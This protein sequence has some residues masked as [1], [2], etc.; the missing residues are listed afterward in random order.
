MRVWLEGRYKTTHTILGGIIQVE[1]RVL[2][3]C[4]D[5]IN[6]MGQAM[7]NIVTQLWMPTEKSRTWDSPKPSPEHWHRH[8]QFIMAW[9]MASKIFT[10]PQR[11][12]SIQ[13]PCRHVVL[14][15][16]LLME[17]KILHM[18]IMP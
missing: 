13:R 4:T 3:V 1:V 11:N 6:P 12:R 7:A 15:H 18:L 2:M 14:T 9:S 5:I 8:L 16:T 10:S 17:D